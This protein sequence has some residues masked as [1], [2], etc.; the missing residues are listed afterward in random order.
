MNELEVDFLTRLGYSL[1]VSPEEFE[2]YQT[3]LMMHVQP[4]EADLEDAE[5]SVETE[6]EAA[7]VMA[8]AQPH[9]G[10]GRE[11]GAAPEAQRPEAGLAA[12]GVGGAGA[13][14]PPVKP[15]E[16][17][18]PAAVATKAKSPPTSVAPCPDARKAA[19]PAPFFSSWSAPWG[20]VLVSVS[21]N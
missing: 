13:V 8:E 16:P 11:G 12:A 6:A 14:P 7:A 19:R 1:K 5:V 9:V 17:P 2:K 18:R 4:A 3:E 21:H 20:S 15:Q 10:S